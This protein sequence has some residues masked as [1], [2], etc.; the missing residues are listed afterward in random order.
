M[1]GIGQAAH[2]RASRQWLDT[3]ELHIWHSQY[4]TQTIDPACKLGERLNAKVERRLTSRH[5]KLMGMFVDHI[6]HL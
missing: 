2:E 6:D 1:V 5:H 4:R 3:S